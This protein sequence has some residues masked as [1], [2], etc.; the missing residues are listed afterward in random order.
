MKSKKSILVEGGGIYRIKTELRVKITNNS[1]N[2]DVPYLVDELI[3]K[4]NS[5]IKG[6]GSYTSVGTIEVIKLK[7]N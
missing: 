7:Q 6:Q 4:I 1:F 5:I 3:N 2:R